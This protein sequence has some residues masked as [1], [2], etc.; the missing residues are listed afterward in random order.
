MKINKKD[1]K[2]PKSVL[3]IA[4]EG[5][6]H[7]GVVY[8]SGIDYKRAP[9]FYQEPSNALSYSDKGSVIKDFKTAVENGP[10]GMYWIIAN[11]Y[12]AEESELVEYAKG[13][14]PDPDQ[15]E[16]DQEYEPRR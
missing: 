13:P 5:D 8:L 2:I 3:L 10:D 12:T 1:F 14:D 4:F 16:E 11:A 15:G 9:E 7:P 6:D